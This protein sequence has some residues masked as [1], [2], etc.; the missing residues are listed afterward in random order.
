MSVRMFTLSKVVMQIRYVIVDNSAQTRKASNELISGLPRAQQVRDIV[1]QLYSLTLTTSIMWDGANA[2]M[3]G[4]YDT[5][6][7]W[8]GLL[9]VV[10][11]H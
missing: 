7:T 11:L 2:Y 3:R 6:Q 8:T 9:A 10:H 1:E 4:Q 5:S